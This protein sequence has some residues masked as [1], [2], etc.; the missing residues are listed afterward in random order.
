MIEDPF[1]PLPLTTEN[2][3]RPNGVMSGHFFCMFC[4]EPITRNQ[5]MNHGGGSCP[6]NPELVTELHRING[7]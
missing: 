1:E 5:G 3:E 4:G 6:E 2:H 7:W